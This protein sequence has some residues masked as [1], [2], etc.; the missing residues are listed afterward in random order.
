[1]KRTFIKLTWLEVIWQRPFEF[2]AV[3]EL[4]THLASV[5]PRAPIIWEARGSH[6]AVH[7]YFATEHQYIKKMKQVFVAHGTSNLPLCRIPPVC[8]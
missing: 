7:Y 4:L 5:T 6:G 1:M 8:R 2:D 3:I